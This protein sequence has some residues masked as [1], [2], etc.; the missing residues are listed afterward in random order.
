[1]VLCSG[2]TDDGAAADGAASI[3]GEATG[4]PKMEDWG[5]AFTDRNTKDSRNGELITSILM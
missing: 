3:D 1:L 2:G 4:V 5:I